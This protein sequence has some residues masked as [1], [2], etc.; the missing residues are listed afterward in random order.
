MI[1]KTFLLI[2]QYLR[3]LMQASIDLEYFSKSFKQTNTMMLKKSGKSNY[4]IT[5]A[6]RSIA[7]ENILDKILESVMTNIISNLTKTYELFSTHHYEEQTKR[8]AKNAMMILIE[9]IYKA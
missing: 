1:K 4:I 8:S 3:T 2:E 7:L 9:N 6:Y 5:K